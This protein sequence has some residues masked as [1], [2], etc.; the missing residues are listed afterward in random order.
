MPVVENC[1]SLQ[2]SLWFFQI[3]FGSCVTVIDDVFWWSNVINVVACQKCVEFSI[4]TSRRCINRLSLVVKDRWATSILLLLS[5]SWMKKRSRGS[6]GAPPIEHTN[7]LCESELELVA[8]DSWLK[9]VNLQI[10]F[11]IISGEIGFRGTFSISSFLF[12]F[13]FNASFF[14]DK[15]VYSACE[16]G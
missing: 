6:S 11:I 10:T 1:L 9:Q 16:I 14:I 15:R 13:F 12:L 7:S 2:I 4:L 3:V 5:T 8:S